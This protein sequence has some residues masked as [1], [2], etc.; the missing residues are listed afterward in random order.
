MLWMKF[1]KNVS[2]ACSSRWHCRHV[3]IFTRVNGG[4]S[5]T[6]KYA[7]IGTEDP[8]ERKFKTEKSAD[9]LTNQIVFIDS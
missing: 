2:P 1:T 4:K 5:K 7:P 8:T 6:V 3:K 9:D